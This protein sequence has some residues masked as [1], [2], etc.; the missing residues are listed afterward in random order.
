VRA[1]LH[2]DRLQ[3]YRLGLVILEHDLVRVLLDGYLRRERQF[4]FAL[5]ILVEAQLDERERVID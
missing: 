2:P 1:P 4:A 3:Q 5:A